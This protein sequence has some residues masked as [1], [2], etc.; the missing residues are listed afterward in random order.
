MSNS[1]FTDPP[2]SLY[3]ADDDEWREARD[4]PLPEDLRDEI[5]S[6]DDALRQPAD[7]HDEVVRDASTRPSDADERS[8]DARGVVAPG[9]TRQVTRDPSLSRDVDLE[10][11]GGDPMA[12]HGMTDDDVTASGSSAPRSGTTR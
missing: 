12:R 10:A 7:A 1:K 8:A 5:Q 11:A 2:A 6:G 3:Q 4:R 9:E